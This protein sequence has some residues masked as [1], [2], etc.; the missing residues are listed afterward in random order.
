[1]YL[2]LKRPTALA[3]IVGAFRILL[4]KNTTISSKAVKIDV[5]V[6]ENLFYSKKS[7]N[8]QVFDLKGSERNRL[9]N[10][11]QQVSKEAEKDLVLLDENFLHWS[12]ENP[13]YVRPH[14]KFVLMQAIDNDSCFLSSYCVM[15][16]SL[17][18]GFDQSSG[19]VWVG[20]IDY[21][22]VFTWDKRAETYFKTTIGGQGKM[23]TIVSPE[24]Y[25]KRFKSAIDR[26]FFE[27]PD[28]WYQ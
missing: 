4:F 2:C 27:V 6:I 25:R 5:I 18:C 24:D 7:S 1:M 26:Y 22:R 19:E 13:I 8:I 15:D 12:F 16:Y 17:L 14:T 3:K 23:P 10:V 20:M 9:V 21:L 11:N 28:Q